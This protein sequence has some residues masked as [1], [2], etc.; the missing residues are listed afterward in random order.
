[1]GK[2]TVMLKQ[3]KHKKKTLQQQKQQK[4]KSVNFEIKYKQK[5]EN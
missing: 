3:Q 2:Y 5:T 4:C 1:M